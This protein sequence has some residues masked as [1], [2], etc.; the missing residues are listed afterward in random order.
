MRP[1]RIAPSEGVPS[2]CIRE[3]IQM[4]PG[5]WSYVAVLGFVLIGCLWLEFAL[6]TRVLVRARR[7]FASMVVPVLVFYAWDAYAV[8][9]GHWTFDPGRILGIRLPGGVPIDEVLF[10]LV[11]PLAAI[12]T[13]EAVR[14]VRGWM[15][16]D[17]S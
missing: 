6:R 15:A 3:D 2:D 9:S 1:I 7:L 16:G 17:E 12:L 5:R 11:I 13:L 4:D 14:S 10:F 8:A